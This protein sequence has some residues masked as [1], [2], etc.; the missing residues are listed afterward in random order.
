MSA[1][2]GEVV[3]F[4]TM[5]SVITDGIFL[6]EPSV[7]N[8]SIRRDMVELNVPIVLTS[9]FNHLDLVKVQHSENFSLLGS[10]S[11]RFWLGMD[12]CLGTSSVSGSD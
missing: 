4:C 9:G 1:G 3:N 5:P 11:I 7:V 2:S 8:C 6:C 12:F 10:I